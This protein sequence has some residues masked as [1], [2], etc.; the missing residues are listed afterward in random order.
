M[1]LNYLSGARDASTKDR[2]G[3]SR[4]GVCL[5][6]SLYAGYFLYC[7][8]SLVFGPA[9]VES[10]RRL[11]ARNAAMESNLEDLG[12]IRQGLNAELDS[13]KS[14][15]ERAA[16]EARSLGYLR[17]D[18]TAIILGEKAEN[19]RPINAGKILPYAEPMALGDLE[20]KEISIGAILAIMAIFLRPR[21]SAASRRRANLRWRFSD[22]A[23]SRPRP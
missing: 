4:L 20:I 9:G 10:Y 6:I 17:K 2:R 12:T 22:K 7:A 23:W 18:E 1:S 8:L 15:P 14:D 11:E 16:L 5:A 3:A 19:V 21:R 13:L